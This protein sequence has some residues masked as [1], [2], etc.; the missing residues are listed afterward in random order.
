MF[1]Q[2]NTP[3]I[4]ARYA[5][6]FSKQFQKGRYMVLEIG[7]KL[8]D[9]MP[10]LFCASPRLSIY[11]LRFLPSLPGYQ[12]SFCSIHQLLSRDYYLYVR[13]ESSDDVHHQRELFPFEHL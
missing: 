11:W 4:P 9:L 10:V 13:I 7:Q 2:V 8:N 5:F 3:R 6:T 12:I 1:K